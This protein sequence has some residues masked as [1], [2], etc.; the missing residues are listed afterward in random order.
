[1]DIFPLEFK[2][3]IIYVFPIFSAHSV[4]CWSGRRWGSVDFG[5]VVQLEG[6]GQLKDINKTQR[7]GFDPW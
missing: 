6:L 7:H 4:L 1:M 5:A 2:T 3:K